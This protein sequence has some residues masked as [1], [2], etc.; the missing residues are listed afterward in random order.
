[1]VR[2]IEVPHGND[3]RVKYMWAGLSRAIFEYTGA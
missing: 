3:V 2:I 1:M